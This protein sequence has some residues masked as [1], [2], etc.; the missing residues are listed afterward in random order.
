MI[1]SVQSPI[2]SDLA[3]LSEDVADGDTQNW[4]LNFIQMISFKFSI[5]FMAMFFVRWV[6][7]AIKRRTN[8]KSFAR[9]NYQPIRTGGRFSRDTSK[10][11]RRGQWPI[12]IPNFGQVVKF[13][14]SFQF[15]PQTYFQWKK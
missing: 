11:T 4:W 15:S 14:F 13:S 7:A 12:R 6:A 2:I 10:T 9:F 8:T 3:P 5:A 1:K